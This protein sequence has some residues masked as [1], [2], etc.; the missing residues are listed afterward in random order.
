MK[1]EITNK[2]RDFNINHLEEMCADLL[3]VSYTQLGQTPD[4]EQV[5]ILTQT[6]AKDL[7]QDFGS[8]L[9]WEDVERS[10]RKGIRDG[11]EF[12]MSVPT[13]YKWLRRWRDIK[14]DSIY[15][16]ETQ[17]KDPK[18][19]PYFKESQNQIKLLT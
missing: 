10:F 9:T 6:L 19:L 1:L 7:M 8:S 4:K 2:I 13:F 14:W 17:G 5:L 18:S 12:H 3:M 11:K 15:Q 16:V